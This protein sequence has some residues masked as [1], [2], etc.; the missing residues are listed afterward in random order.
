M[1]ALTL[2][3]FRYFD[4]LAR[5]GHFGRAAEACAISQPAL[6]MQIR[7]LEETIGAPLLERTA[8]QARLTRVGERLL[9]QVREI[10]RSVDQIEDIARA[11]NPVPS[12]ALRLGIIPTIAPYLLPAIMSR[13]GCRFPDLVAQPRETTTARLLDDLRDGR[14]DA[15]I[16]ALPVSGAGLTEVTLFDEDFLLVCPANHGARA[17]RVT[18]DLSDTRLLL[19][20]E[21]HC[22]RDQALAFCGARFPRPR[23]ILDGSSLTTLVQMVGAGIGMTLLPEMAVAVETRLAP[24]TVSRLADPQPRR[25]IGM[26]WRRSDPM[27]SQLRQIADVV[28]AAGLEG[29]AI[30][31]PVPSAP[32]RPGLALVDATV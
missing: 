21:G 2:R 25:R 18:D 27:Y 26:V 16:L 5:L 29:R 11:A 3:Q 28:R 9:I 10:L 20:E 6:S 17:P 8:R 7:D 30:R 15:A 4:A 24:V 22:F 23:E 12:G 1:K 31:C 13:L 14:L 19:L 32:D